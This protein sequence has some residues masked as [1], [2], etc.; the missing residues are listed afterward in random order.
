M[1]MQGISTWLWFDGQAELAATF[2]AELFGGEVTGVERAPEGT[3]LP[4]GEVMTASF[5]IL[6]HDFNALNGGPRFRHSSATSFMVQCDDQAEIDRLWAAL[7]DGGT[8]QQCGW[9]VDR[10][11]VTWQIVPTRLQELLS[12]GGDAAA[13]QRVWQAMMPMTKL[14]IAALE[15]AADG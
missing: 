4:A 14:D 5:R 13:S 8:E 3:P 1:L 10:F 7:S 2:Y 11:G 6:G 15:S 12:G 9:V